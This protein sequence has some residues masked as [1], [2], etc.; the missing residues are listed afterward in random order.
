MM[1][2]LRDLV[3]DTQEVDQGKEFPKRELRL[4]FCSWIRVGIYG[5]LVHRGK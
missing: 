4:G 1:L 5:W 2:A 3:Q